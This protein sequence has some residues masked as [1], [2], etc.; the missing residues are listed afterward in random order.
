MP[1]VEE[2]ILIAASP[3][4][5]FDYIANQPEKMPD[6][7][8]PMILQERVTPPPTE[9]G[10]VSRFVYNMLGVEIKGEHRVLALIPNRHL[11]VTTTSGIDS[12]F[13][14]TFTPEGDGCRLT[15]RVDYTLPGSVLGQL[16]NRMVVERQNVKDLQ[17]GLQNLRRILEGRG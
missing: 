15:I 4:Q 9:I 8:P 16:L 5:V 14:F 17:E 1:Y 7:W 6:W 10:S 3:E 11:N 2:S 12:S 13:D